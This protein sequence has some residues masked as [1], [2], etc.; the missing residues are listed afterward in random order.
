MEEEKL[1]IL[2][3]NSS[4]HTSYHINN[5]TLLPVTSH[6]DLGVFFSSDLK[7]NHHYEYIIAKILGLLLRHLSSNNYITTKKFF[8][9]P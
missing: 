3:F 6:K 8:T 4:Q 1:S 2:Q 9:Y 5:S 7:W